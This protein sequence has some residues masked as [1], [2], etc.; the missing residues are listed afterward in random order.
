MI[1][2]WIGMNPVINVL[3]NSMCMHTVAK[4]YSLFV[5]IQI[6]N[7]TSHQKVIMVFM[8]KQEHQR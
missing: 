3:Y 4:V 8:N 7:F 2:K 5:V 1:R 6:F